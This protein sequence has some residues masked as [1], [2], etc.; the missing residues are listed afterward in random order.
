MACH[1]RFSVEFS[2]KPR[3]I[4]KKRRTSGEHTQRMLL[5]DLDDFFDCECVIGDRAIAIGLNFLFIG[6]LHAGTN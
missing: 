1:K 3:R 2:G 5:I 6:C 4:D